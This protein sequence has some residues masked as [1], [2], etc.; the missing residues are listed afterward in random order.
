[1]FD[2]ILKESKVRFHVNK[3]D[4]EFT[5]RVDGV[6]FL[7]EKELKIE[8]IT[9]NFSQ[10]EHVSY[11]QGNTIADNTLMY[12]VLPPEKRLIH[13]VRLYL[14]TERYIRQSNS[15]T[16]KESKS[17]IL[18]E[19]GKQNVL[20]NT[21]LINTLNHL[22]GQATIYMNGVENR[23][24][25][26]SDGRTR[27]IESAQDLILLAYPKLQLLGSSTF[28]EGQLDLIMTKQSGFV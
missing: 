16:T 22:L 10:Y 3:Q 8:I 6:M 27:I 18:Y 9:P 19:K 24:S 20:R 15:S 7:R 14:Q 2:G 25:T 23:S 11:Y 1:M 12:V 4:F 21:Q 17:R 26:S 28:D 5:R 13:E